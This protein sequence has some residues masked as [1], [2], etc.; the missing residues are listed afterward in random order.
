MLN[1]K[2]FV[3]NCAA[4]LCGSCGVAAAAEPGAACDP[5]ELKAAAAHLDGAQ[6]RFAK[7]VE[8]LAQN[9]PA[10]SAAKLLHGLGG[11]CAATYKA[12]LLDRFKGDIHVESEVGKGTTFTVIL[13][14]ENEKN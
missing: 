14:V 6:Y 7:L 13:P 4:A 9:L 10:E 3:R 5:K 11:Q 8:Q 12:E 1:R 2:E